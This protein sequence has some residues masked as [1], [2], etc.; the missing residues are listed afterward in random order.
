MTTE[1]G[2]QFAKEHGLIFLE[3]SARTAH[4]VEDVSV[5]YCLAL[6]HE[7]V[8]HCFNPSC[9]HLSTRPRR[10]TA[11]SKM[12]FSTYRMRWASLHDPVYFHNNNSHLILSSLAPSQSYGIKVGYGAGASGQPGTG[13]KVG[14]EPKKASGCC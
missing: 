8:P 1:E 12:E 5:S 9:R 3:T 4:N 10:S 13:A 6:P 2:E 7:P 11:K 14:E